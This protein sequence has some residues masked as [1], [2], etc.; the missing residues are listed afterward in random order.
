MHL[1]EPIW[2]ERFD[3]FMF[4]NFSLSEWYLIYTKALLF[5]ISESVSTKVWT[6]ELL[7][8]VALPNQKHS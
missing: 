4:Q 5:F 8:K 1:K 3:T 2:A 6:E 7:L